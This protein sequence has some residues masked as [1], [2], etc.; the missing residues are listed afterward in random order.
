MGES[1]FY[2][3]CNL[4]LLMELES[5]TWTEFRVSALGLDTAHMEILEAKK[6]TK[7]LRKKFLEYK[8]LEVRKEKWG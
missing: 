8:K 3:V 2:E 5:E 7:G 4:V 1:V 6:V